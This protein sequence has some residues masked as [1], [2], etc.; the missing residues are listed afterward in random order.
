MRN[1]AEIRKNITRTRCLVCCP[2]TSLFTDTHEKLLSA[3]GYDVK[4][5]SDGDKALRSFA[6]MRPDIFIVHH[7]FLP[8]SP[9]RL[10]QVFR[11]VHR[12]P[13]VLILTDEI[14]QAWDYIN[15]KYEPY[16]EYL[17][18]PISSPQELALSVKLAADRLKTTG[19]KRF[20][21]DLITQIAFALPVL[22]LLVYLLL[23]RL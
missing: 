22:A 4:V 9:K 17:K 1:K 3:L 23:E 16:I 21:T 8:A 12:K 7:T 2:D 6:D 14:T 5:I 13:A 10:L 18:S 20:Y 19:R 15:L 11:L